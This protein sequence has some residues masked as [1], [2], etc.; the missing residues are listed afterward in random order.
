M[1]SGYRPTERRGGLNFL[2]V[3]R[4]DLLESKL[5]FAFDLDFHFEDIFK[6]DNVSVLVTFHFQCHFSFGYILILVTF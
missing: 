4:A 1:R 5:D 3:M 6:F 2:E